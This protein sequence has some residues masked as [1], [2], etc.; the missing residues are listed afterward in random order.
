MNFKDADIAKYL[1]NPDLSVKCVL[2]YGNN[3]GKIADYTSQ[4]AKTVCSDLSDAFQVVNLNMENVSKDIGILF[5]EYNAQSLLGGRRVIIIK[6]GTDL[7]TKHLKT[8]FEDNKSDTLLIITSTSLTTKSS[9]VTM[10]KNENYFAGIGCYDD[11]EKDISSFVREYLIKNQITINPNAFELLCSKLSNDRKASLSEMDKLITYLGT[12]RNIELDDIKIAVS[13]TSGSSLE[14]LCYYVA[15]GNTDKAIDAYK[16]LLH[17]GTEE[18]SIIR[19][20][21]SHF[22]NLLS[23]ASNIEKGK[24]TDEII[25]SI[26]P[27]VMFYRKDDLKLQ[28]NIWKKQTIL[29]VIA[30]LYQCEKDCKTTN[31]PTENILSYCIM[32]ISGAAKKL[33]NNFR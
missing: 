12:R 27:P 11:R 29:D 32:Q 3:E 8:L 33:K 1:K 31:M 25:A 6:E 18:V 28:I 23:Y 24:R 7:L 21:S 2:I 22:L 13:D 4:F 5:G 16:E 30:K 26:R 9:L 19:A 10:A 15:S 20:L 17:E 14:D